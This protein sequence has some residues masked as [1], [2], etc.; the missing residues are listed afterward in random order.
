MLPGPP[1]T[2]TRRIPRRGTLARV[3]I[4]VAA[5]MLFGAGTGCVE[6][7]IRIDSAPQGALVY[8]NDREIGRTPVEVG[9]V[10]YGVYDLR[11]VKPGFEPLQANADAS[12]PWWD[13][14]GFDF[15]SEISPF[16]QRVKLD[17]TYTLTPAADGDANVRERANEM[18]DA[19]TPRDTRPLQSQ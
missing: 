5:V 10:H 19:V 1:I 11:M 9:F 3:G 12:P 14:P 17:W 13:A 2:S 16:R 8:L 4:T 18:R 15:F 7:V 6:R